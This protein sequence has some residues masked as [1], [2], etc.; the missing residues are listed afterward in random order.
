MGEPAATRPT[1]GSARCDRPGSDHCLVRVS[2]I[3]CSASRFRRMPGYVAGQVPVA[4]LLG[5]VGAPA[6]FTLHAEQ[7]AQIDSKD[8]SF[9]V[10]QSLYARCVHWLAQGDVAGIVVTHG[11]DTLEE[12]AYFLHRVLEA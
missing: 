8:M 11:T 10:W 1:R 6:G 7:L 5:G 3:A 12:T 4:D 9:G 2:L